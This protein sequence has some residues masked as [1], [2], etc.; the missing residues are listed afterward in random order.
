MVPH[1]EIELFWGDVRLVSARTR[2]PARLDAVLHETAVRL[3]ADMWIE[4]AAHGEVRIRGAGAMLA[5][6]R[7]P[8]SAV[9]EVDGVR[10]VARPAD[11]VA[12]LPRRGID[13]TW[14]AVLFLAMAMVAIGSRVLL[15]AADRPPSVSERRATLATLARWAAR[16][17]DPA[18]RREPSVPS[19]DPATSN[20][21][22]LSDELPDPRSQ[23]IDRESSW[24]H[25]PAS[26]LEAVAHRG[27]LGLALITPRLAGAMTRTHDAFG[28]M[29]TAP[30]L[31]MGTPDDRV[32]YGTMGA[33]GVGSGSGCP[34]GTDCGTVA[35]RVSVGD[36][37][38]APAAAIAHASMQAR[39]AASPTVRVAPPEMGELTMSYVQ[40]R[41]RRELLADVVRCYSDRLEQT[42]TL[43]SG[44]V[45]VRFNVSTEGRVTDASI[46]S[47]A[48]G[49]PEI[50]SCVT[51][52][53]RS[54]VFPTNESG[55]QVTYPF[56][57]SS[58]LPVT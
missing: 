56:V 36:G 24:S 34:P 31:G 12:A 6:S 41:I 55:A 47:S 28:S 52:T 14:C 57:F 58:V 8:E 11:P 30:I 49:Q 26:E 44:R 39:T 43:P 54:A 13:R 16:P 19:E 10:V 45:V 17:A 22:G 46:V 53:L 15:R 37:W 21:P 25:G 4:V 33:V 3:D 50:E 5:V 51:R 20:E 7:G 35:V 42:P 2:L 23:R 29:R 9:V 40:Q 38:R 48:I 27:I 32:R 1:A 18:H